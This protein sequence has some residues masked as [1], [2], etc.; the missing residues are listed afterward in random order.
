MNGPGFVDVSGW[1]SEEVK[2]LGQMDDDYPDDYRKT[3]RNPYAYRRPVNRAPKV[4]FNYNAD[5]V[6]AAAVQA[7][8][9]N[10]AY[11]KAI[12]PGIA[13]HETNRML[14]ERLLKD[15]SQITQES[16]DKGIQVRKYFQAFTF[17][18]LQG[19]TLNDFSKTAMDI[20]NRDVITSTYDLAVIASLPASYEKSTARDNVD[21]RINFARG[22]T[23]GTIGD[24]VTIEIEILKKVW[25]VKWNTHYIT[26]ITDDDKVLFFSYNHNI[27]IGD[28]VTI[29]GIVKS[30]TDNSTQLNRVKVIK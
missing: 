11:I 16:R 24:K 6:W 9:V 22:G 30:H 13:Q 4:N 23:L 28:R 5:D 15:T 18:V 8:A 19:K 21:R 7:Q 27:E 2:R 10:G 29:Q 3:Y 14:V 12:A 26:G 1:S 20:S 17:K 25:S